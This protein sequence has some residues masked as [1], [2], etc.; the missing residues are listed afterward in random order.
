MWWTTEWYQ[1]EEGNWYS[2]LEDDCGM[3]MEEREEY[4]QL[5]PWYFATQMEA[6]Q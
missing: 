4:R 1:D 3:T 5:Q 2:R 6:S